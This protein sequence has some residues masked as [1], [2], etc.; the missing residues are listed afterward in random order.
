[1]KPIALIGLLMLLL[2]SCQHYDDVNSYDSAEL[3]FRI[4]TSAVGTRGSVTDYPTTPSQWSQAERAADGRY[5]YALSVY[6]L[7]DKKQIV[8]AQENITVSNEATEAV[9]TFD[10]SYNLKRGV[11][12]VMAVANHTDH[13]IGSTTYSGGLTAEWKAGD[14]QSLMSNIISGHATD[15]LSPKNVMQPLSLIK[16][17]E[18][19]AGNN[20]VEG[21]L[22][23]TFARIRIEVK[24]N[25]GTLPLTINSLSFSNNFSQRQ[26]YVFDDGS[27]RKYFG[28]KGAPLSTSTNA[29]MPFTY[30]ESSNVKTIEARSSAVVF[31]SY[32]LESKLADND[33]Y[34]YTLDLSYAATVATYSY[35]PNWTAI[36]DIS[37][38]NVGNES[39]FLIY[40]SNRKRYL[41]A[42]NDKVGT[43]TLSTSI[44]TVATALVWQ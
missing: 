28:A 27:D 9:V 4:A 17:I 16:S 38:M 1:M 5:I 8:A 23:R 15:N 14:Y 6:I 2:A 39:Y 19:H 41:S 26:A 29:L 34:K 12:T 37:S 36:N 31:D 20:V 40:N 44:S 42:D 7:N 24:N 10:K 11:Y 13:K 35:E 3:T 21:E 43:A 18:L 32:L 30:D 22:V 33:F 25:S